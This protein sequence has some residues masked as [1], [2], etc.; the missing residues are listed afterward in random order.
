MRAACALVLDGAR[1]AAAEGISPVWR[2]HSCPV[3]TLSVLACL[4]TFRCS[5]ALGSGLLSVWLRAVCA[6]PHLGECERVLPQA[7]HG[8]GVE[9]QLWSLTLVP[10]FDSSG[11][12]SVPA[13]GVRTGCLCRGTQAK[14]TGEGFPHIQR[15]R[16]C[17]FPWDSLRDCR[18]LSIDTLRLGLPKWLSV[19]EHD[20]F[21]HM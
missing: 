14:D 1:R 16:P 3:H 5:W 9:P 2:A 13:F 20:A 12:F 18:G 7:A 6:R 10:G 11:S 4:T 17:P 19:D 21:L 15:I 8:V